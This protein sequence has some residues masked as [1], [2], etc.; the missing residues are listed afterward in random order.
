MSRTPSAWVVL[1]GALLVSAPASA[2]S[3]ELAL[4]FQNVFGPNGL[5][6]NSEAVLPDGSTH[7][8]HFNSAFQSNF[9]QIN[10]AL[11]SQLTAL[12][13]PSPASGFTYAFDTDTG[14]FVRS[15]QSFGPIL[16]DRAETLGRG[17]FSFGFNSQFFSFDTLEGVDLSNVP[18]VFTHDEVELGG[19]RLDVVTTANTIQASVAQMTAVIAYG[20]TNRLDI[21]LAV[22]MVRTRLAV[23]SLATVRR[24]GTADSP[25]T[26]FFRDE[27]AP[28][29][30]GTQRQFSSSGSASGM[31]DLIVRAKG[32]VLREARR[33]LA[34]GVEMRLPTGN[35]R[36]LL[37]S[38]APGAKAFVAFSASYRRL[39]PHVNVG[40]Q[41]NGKSVLAGDLQ[42]GRKERLPSQLLYALGLDLGVNPRLTLAADLLGQR[43]IDSPRLVRR[44]VPGANGAG[45]FPDIGFVTATYSITAGSVG[46]KINLAQR[47]LGTFNVRFHLGSS[48]LADRATPLV[49]VEYGF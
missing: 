25:A 12:P 1:V 29:T 27:D 43:I 4:I 38:G 46:F 6:V 48:G 22:P 44:T 39:S 20:V 11:A 45:D 3:P 41:W 16:T 21:S 8:A 31:G 26:H 5:R 30:L 35:E 17:K 37:G 13:L 32:T 47:L 34:A 2:Q 7:S 33:A 28:G 15:T 18:A 49:G 42:T 40:Y 9:T 24:I 23:S 14:T 10:I 19:G 36:N